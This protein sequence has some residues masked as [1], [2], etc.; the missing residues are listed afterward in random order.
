MTEETRQNLIWGWLRFILG[1]LQLTLSPLAFLVL[2]LQGIYDLTFWFLL[3]TVTIITLISRLL[4][5]GQP[6]PRL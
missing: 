2:I 5:S 4:Y 3:F 6:D 1:I